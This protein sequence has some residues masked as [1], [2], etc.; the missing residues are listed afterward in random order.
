MEFKTVKWTSSA[1]S[2]VHTVK[3]ISDTR[4]SSLKNSLEVTQWWATTLQAFLITRVPC[5]QELTLFL[6]CVCYLFFLTLEAF[7]SRDVGMCSLANAEH[8]CGRLYLSPFPWFTILC[9]LCF[10]AEKLDARREIQRRCNTEGRCISPLLRGDFFGIYQFL[11]LSFPKIVFA[12]GV[13]TEW[14]ENKITVLKKSISLVILYKKGLSG[15][16]LVSTLWHFWKVVCPLAV[17]QEKPSHT[18]IQTGSLSPSLQLK[19]KKR[20]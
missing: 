20:K 15:N 7:G 8:G 9:S 16:H 6:H 5:I 11:S 18:L 10:W 13:L 14:K 12:S 4:I 2:Y 17:K 3:K 1:I 19:K